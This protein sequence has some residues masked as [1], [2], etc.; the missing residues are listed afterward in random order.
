[1]LGLIRRTPCT[2][3]FQNALQIRSI[4]GAADISIGRKLLQCFLL[5]NILHKQNYL[6]IL[7]YQYLH[8]MLRLRILQ[9]CS[10]H[11]NI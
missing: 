8:E 5:P 1:M 9:D 3:L 7:L 6:T 4:N 10:I 2:V 11:I